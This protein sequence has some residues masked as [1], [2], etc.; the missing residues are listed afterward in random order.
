MSLGHLGR[1]QGSSVPRAE[2]E[3][4]SKTRPAAY[5]SR[6]RLTRRRNPSRESQS[7]ARG[8]LLP[9]QVSMLP[10]LEGGKEWK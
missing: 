10:D 6:G 9:C 2:W 1:G 8:E 5:E 3:R 4:D 7:S